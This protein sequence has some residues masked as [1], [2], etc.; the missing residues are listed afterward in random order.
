M[1]KNPESLDFHCLKHKTLCSRICCIFLQNAKSARRNEIGIVPFI[2]KQ[3]YGAF[4][5]FELSMTYNKTVGGKVLHGMS[6]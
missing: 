3:Y 1:K 4:P 2:G 6:H 5:D